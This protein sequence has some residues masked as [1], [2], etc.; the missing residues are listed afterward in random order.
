M[1]K[2]FSRFLQG[3]LYIY[4]TLKGYSST[5]KWKF[6]YHL[7]TLK[8]LQTC[9]RFFLLLNTKE[10]I[11]K[12]DWDFGIIDYHSIYYGS[13]W[14]KTTVWFQSF[15]KISSF[16]FSRRNK[17]IQVCHNLRVSKLWQN[18]LFFFILLISS[19]AKK[20]Y[21][22]SINSFVSIKSYCKVKRYCVILHLEADAWCLWMQSCVT[23]LRAK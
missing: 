2:L 9:M 18:F 16:V 3:I 1:L 19:D 4:G 5:Q 8:F 6:S 21:L 22:I 11:L 10:D 7:L 23:V 15:F 17:L 20:S 12:N 13:Q 14:C